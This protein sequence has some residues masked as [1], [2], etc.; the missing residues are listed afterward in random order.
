MKGEAVNP[1]EIRVGVV[2][3]DAGAM[4]L[5]VEDND[6]KN[7]YMISPTIKFQVSDE[8][9]HAAN[10]DLPHFLLWFVQKGG[11]LTAK[12]WPDKNKYELVTRAEF[13]R[14]PLP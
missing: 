12:L 4:Y 8:G 1:I 6:G 3:L 5:A 2:R 11:I 14:K 13:H 9:G 10:V 7:S